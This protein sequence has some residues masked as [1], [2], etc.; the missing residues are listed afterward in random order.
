[1]NDKKLLAASV[2]ILL[3]FGAAAFA[4]DIDFTRATKIALGSGN[5][6]INRAGDYT[7]SGT[8]RNG[9]VLIDP[10]KNGVVRL[11]LNGAS[12]ENPNGA[13]IYMKSGAELIISLAAG[14]E[15]TLIDGKNYPAGGAANSG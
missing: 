1:M 3:C 13:A 11:Q 2:I 9:Q 8:L 4:Q 12:I 15:N 5:V 7:L 6:T 10:G 14:T